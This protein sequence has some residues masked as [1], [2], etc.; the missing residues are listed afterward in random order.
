MLNEVFSGKIISVSAGTK[1]QKNEDGTV[2]YT[3]LCKFKIE[4]DDIDYDSL[5]KFN[6]S[7]S[8]TLLN[9]QPMPFKDVDFGDLSMFGLCLDLFKLEDA[10]SH[11]KEVPDAFYKNVRIKDL[12]VKNKANIPIYIFS[13]EMVIENS[14]SFLFNNVKSEVNFKFTKGE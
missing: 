7:V 12:K 11:N 4:S 13:F 5:A 3:P 2:S 1:K 8:A 14:I 9:I 6:S 10:D